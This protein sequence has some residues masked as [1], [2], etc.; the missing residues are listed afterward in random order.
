MATLKNEN[1]FPTDFN[2]LS[3]DE[4]LYYLYGIDIDEK[5]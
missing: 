5:K 4:T 3:Y 2:N 1:W